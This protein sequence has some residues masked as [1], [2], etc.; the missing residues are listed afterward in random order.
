MY[1]IYESKKEFFKEKIAVD[2]TTKKVIIKSLNYRNL[3]LKDNIV[4]LQKDEN[5]YFFKYFSE[6]YI[7]NKM[8]L[9]TVVSHLN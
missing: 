8:H 7:L 9:Q 2:F 1:Y 6:V 4:K 5:G 3:P